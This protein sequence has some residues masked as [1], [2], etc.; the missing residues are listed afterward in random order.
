MQIKRGK[1]GGKK[2][3]FFHVYIKRRLIY[4]ETI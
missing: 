1:D 2:V 4:E 3:V